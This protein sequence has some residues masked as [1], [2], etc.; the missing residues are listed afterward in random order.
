MA[1][2]P[3]EICNMALIELGANTIS[4]L[5]DATPE[6]QACNAVYEFERRAL[7]RSHHWNFALEFQ[8]LATSTP[9]PDF[10]YDNSFPLPNSCLKVIR[11][12][13][14]TKEFIVKGR[15]IYT[16]EDVIKLLFVKDVTDAGEFDTTFAETLALRVAVRIGYKLTQSVTAV[17]RVE[18]KLQVVLRDARSFDAQE[19]TPEDFYD[20]HWLESRW[21]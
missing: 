5:T 6:A 14:R 8:E 16:D 18:Q 19:G 9:A 3:V 13:D 15:N 7:L 10:E 17:Q 2:T 12:N 11:V 1:T 21:S 20:E 4:S